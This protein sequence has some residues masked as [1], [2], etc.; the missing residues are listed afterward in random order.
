MVGPMRRA[1]ADAL[2]ALDA[3]MGKEPARER[4]PRPNR[5][6]AVEAPPEPVETVNEPED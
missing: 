6:G 5:R 4:P 2:R 3:Q 1:A